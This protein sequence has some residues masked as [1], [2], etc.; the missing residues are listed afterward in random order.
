MLYVVIEYFN[1]GAAVEIYRRARDRGRQLPPG[2][3]YVDSWVDLDYFRCFQPMRTN[4]LALF[5]IRNIR[6][7]DWND[8]GHF[9]IIP[10]RTS[11]EV[12]QHIADK[13]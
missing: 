6:I 7:K 1:V 10:V 12:A 5:D 2:L 11:A 13:L 3:E 8:L 9:E 4:D